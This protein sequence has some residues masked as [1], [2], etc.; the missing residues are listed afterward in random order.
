MRKSKA[1]DVTEKKGVIHVSKVAR[2]QDWF[3][4]LEALMDNS[5]SAMNLMFS[6]HKLLKIVLCFFMFCCTRVIEWEAVTSHLW[7]FPFLDLLGALPR[8]G[9]T[10]CLPLWRRSLYCPQL[11]VTPGD[12]PKETHYQLLNSRWLARYVEP[13]KWEQNWKPH[14]LSSIVTILLFMRYSRVDLSCL[15]L[16][17]QLNYLIVVISGGS[18][19]FSFFAFLI[20]L[21]KPKSYQHSTSWYFMPVLEKSWIN[22]IVLQ[23]CR[24]LSPNS[25][26]GWRDGSS[27]S[28]QCTHCA[29]SCRRVVSI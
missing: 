24:F 1:I 23:E 4:Q 22:I 21:M 14:F 17:H 26:K 28:G 18:G 3:V 29:D 16:C 10:K 8:I 9:V 6:R 11:P 2:S 15:W 20:A 25:S 5:I 7:C 13:I 12:S 27:P 19:V